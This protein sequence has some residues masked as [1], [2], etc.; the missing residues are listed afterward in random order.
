[1]KKMIKKLAEFLR[2]VFGWG[3]V[4]VLFGGGLTFIGYL[5]ALCIGGDG[6][7]AIC[8]VIYKQI[9]PVLIRAANILVLLGLAAMYLSGEQ[10]LTAKKKGT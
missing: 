4:L 8:H 1:M 9:W 6:A 5:V 2:A 7:A 10:A 3:I